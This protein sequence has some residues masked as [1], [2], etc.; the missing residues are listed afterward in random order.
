VTIG[1][2]SPTSVTDVASNNYPFWNIDYAYSKTSLDATAQ[3]KAAAALIQDIN[4]NSS[5]SS[6]DLPEL[7]W[8]PLYD[9]SGAVLSCHETKDACN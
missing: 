9:F 8:L 2:Y 7:E 6:I 5:F 3:G 4:A 1:H